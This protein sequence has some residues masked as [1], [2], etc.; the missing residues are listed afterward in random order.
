[1]PIDLNDG[2]QPTKKKAKTVER[3]GL[4]KVNL[5]N[6]H[7]YLGTSYHEKDCSLNIW[8]IEDQS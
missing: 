1:M 2:H 7:W 8:I 5:D 6:R 3:I 4:E